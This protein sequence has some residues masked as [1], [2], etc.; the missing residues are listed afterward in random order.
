MGLMKNNTEHRLKISVAGADELESIYSLRH[1]VYATELGQYESRSDESL[2]DAGDVASVYI[3]ASLD[4]K[5]AGFVGITHHNIL[6]IN[7]YPE[8]RF[9]SPLMTNFMKFVRLQSKKT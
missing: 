7:S 4:G 1:D 8:M 6:W 9:H 5:L 2:P 3:A